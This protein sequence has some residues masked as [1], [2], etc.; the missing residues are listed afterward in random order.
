[1]FSIYYRTFGLPEV[2]SAP[3]STESFHDLTTRQKRYKTDENVEYLKDA[4]SKNNLSKNE[5]L[6]YMLY[7]CDY[8]ENRNDDFNC[9]S[10]FAGKIFFKQLTLPMKPKLSI[11]ETIT[12]QTHLDLSRRDVRFSTT[13]QQGREFFSEKHRLGIV[14]F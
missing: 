14:E 4:A 6:G 2:P 12:I 5:F 8:N 13:G 7:R 11:D 1:M 3:V 10:S 9:Q